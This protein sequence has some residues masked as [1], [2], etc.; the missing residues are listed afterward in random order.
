VGSVNEVMQR[1]SP[2]RYSSPFN[3]SPFV[4]GKGVGRRL[5]PY[6]R[7]QPPSVID[8]DS[9]YNVAGGGVVKAQPEARLSVR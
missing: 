6:D 9:Q 5:S 8:F 2:E 3:S 7:R 1:A 4:D